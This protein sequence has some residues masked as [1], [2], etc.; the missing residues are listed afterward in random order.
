MI[1]HLYSIYDKVADV[2]NKPFQE[3]N[4]QAAIRGFTDAIA[5]EK[6][7]N[8]YVL[9]LIADFDNTNG[10]V[11]ESSGDGKCDYPKKLMTGFDINQKQDHYSDFVQSS[12]EV[13]KS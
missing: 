8:D 1:V 2:F 10:S 4:D 13:K 5:E 6:H 12:K 3:I 9:Y 7:K 11:H